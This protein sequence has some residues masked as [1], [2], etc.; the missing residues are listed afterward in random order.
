MYI[1]VLLHLLG[2]RAVLGNLFN[3]LGLFHGY[4]VLE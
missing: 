2:D 4:E 1:H 3:G